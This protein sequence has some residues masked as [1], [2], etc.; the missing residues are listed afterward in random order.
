MRSWPVPPG[1][2]VIDLGCGDGDLPLALVNRP[3]IL[4]LDEPTSG[5]N[6]LMIEKLLNIIQ[7]LAKAG[8]TII[9]SEHNIPVV[10][11]ISDRVYFMSEGKIIASGDPQKVLSN[12]EIKATYIGV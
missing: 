7:N 3:Q 4:L 12:P 5:I 1:A 10:T 9:I 2:S 6:P 8:K 11:E